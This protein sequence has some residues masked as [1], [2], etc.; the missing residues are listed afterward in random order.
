MPAMTYSPHS[1]RASTIGPA[2]LLALLLQKPADSEDGQ[3]ESIPKQPIQGKSYDV[4]TAGV[5]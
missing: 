5:K 1:F 4:H 2:E 3:G